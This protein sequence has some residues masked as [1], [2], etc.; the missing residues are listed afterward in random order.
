[1][2]H[3]PSVRVGTLEL[4]PSVIVERVLQLFTE[5]LNLKSLSQKLLLEVVDLLPEIANLSGLRFDNAE[6]TL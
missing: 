1:L 5:G 6:L 2:E 4:P 3:F